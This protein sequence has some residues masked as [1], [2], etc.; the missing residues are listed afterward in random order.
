MSRTNR[1]A[2]RIAP[3]VGFAKK[4]YTTAPGTRM[5]PANSRPSR[6]VPS[7]RDARMYRTGIGRERSRSLS[8]AMYSPEKVLN[9]LPN[10]PSAVAI[11]ENSTKYSQP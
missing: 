5:M 7:R 6:Y 3:A 10:T 9:T 11:S 1:S 2:P 4:K 8:F